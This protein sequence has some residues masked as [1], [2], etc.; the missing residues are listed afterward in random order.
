MQGL[1]NMCAPLIKMATDM[2]ERSIPSPSA[3][4]CIIN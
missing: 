2:Q 3:S 4:T 1:A